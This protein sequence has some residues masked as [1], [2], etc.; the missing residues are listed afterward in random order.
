MTTYSN[1]TFIEE[2]PAVLLTQDLL[3]TDD[4][5]G[6]KQFNEATI[7]IQQGRVLLHKCILIHSLISVC[8]C[9]LY[10]SVPSCSS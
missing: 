1:V 7:T 9:T 4:D 6:I 5:I 8:S 3:I 2:G 10:P